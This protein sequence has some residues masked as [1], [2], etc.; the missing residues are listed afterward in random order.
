MIIPTY[1]EN[2]NLNLQV[3]ET[4]FGQKEY[5]KLCKLIKGAY[6]II[7]TD[8]F[9]IND[10]WHRIDNGKIVLDHETKQWI[11]TPE[12]PFTAQTKGVVGITDTEELI[13]GWFTKNPYRNIF[14]HSGDIGLNSEILQGK[15]VEDISNDV[16]IST[17]L[18][19]EKNIKEMS[20][21][22]KPDKNYSCCTYNIDDDKLLFTRQIELYNK[23]PTIV[24]QSSKKLS[25]LIGN[26]TFGIEVETSLG[27]VPN[28]ICN[29]LGLVA[30]KDGSLGENYKSAEWV[31]VPMS[32]AKGLQNIVDISK[33]TSQRCQIDLN[34]SYHIHYGNIPITRN[35]IVSLYILSYKLQN[36]LF[37]MFPYY[38]TDYRDVKQ[39][40]YCEKLK[41]LGLIAL[42]DQSQKGYKDYIN[43]AYKQIFT[44]L[45]EGVEPDENCNINTLIHPIKDKWM[46]KNSRYRYMNLQNMIFSP[47]RTAEAR[48]HTPTTN[49]L[50]M[51]TWFFMNLAII[52]YA[53]IHEQSIITGKKITL[54]DVFDYFKDTFK[55]EDA[56][57]VSQYLKN[58]YLYQKNIF[59][60]DWNVNC[61]KVSFHDIQQDKTFDFLYKE[62]NLLTI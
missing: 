53:E 27:K 58:Y 48:L 5:R 10:K 13:R 4:R 35:Y 17:K 57:Y 38:K 30:C 36:E 42:K 37:E 46:R 24:N 54:F 50:K 62:K 40:N 1:K 49:A 11:L 32:G 60:N 61:D 12:N 29:Q 18:L 21:I 39:K 55:T 44:F 28:N 6:Y 25:K 34:C 59:Q 33:I 47:R 52:R 26:I 8:C 23:F 9:F 14:L 15:Y 22:R 19:S 3:V 7:N 16:W 56:E 2:P 31:S 45:S 41:K 51:T 20:N 43:F